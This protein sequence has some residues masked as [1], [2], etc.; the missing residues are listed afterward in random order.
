LS[1]HT[2][3]T[4]QLMSMADG[5][6]IHLN[7]NDPLTLSK[8]LHRAADHANLHGI[9]F[10]ASNGNERFQTYGEMREDARRVT[11]GLARE[12]VRAGDKVILL[13]DDKSEYVP[14]FWGC[15]LGGHVPV[16]LTP[17][18]TAVPSQET[19][20]FTYIYELLEN[21]VII[22]D[23]K[24]RELLV[25][26]R[27]G[28]PVRAFTLEEISADASMA[29][30]HAT[31]PDDPA[32]MM[33]TSGSTGKPKGVQLTHRQV[34][35]RELSSIRHFGFDEKYKSVNWMPLE[36]VGGIIMLHITDV[37]TCSNQ[38]LVNTSYI[39]E[40]PF[41]WLDLLSKH[42]ATTTWAS[43][44]AFNLVNEHLALHPARDWDLSSV[45]FMFNGGEAVSADISVQFSNKLAPYGLSSNA[46][47]PAWGMSETCSGVIFS[48]RFDAATLNGI[49]RWTLYPSYG[50]TVEQNPEGRSALV[51]V[52][53]PLPGIRIKI[54]DD[55][56][57]LMPQGS[58][59]NLM[60]S[61]PMV[62]EQYYGQPAKSA[63]D[64][65]GWFD[66]GDLG[67]LVDGHLILTGR[68]K[69]LI[70]INGRNLSSQ[71][72]EQVVE[73][74]DQVKPA[75]TS[76]C[77]SRNPVSQEE[78]MVVF[79]SSAHTEP[80]AISAQILAI[81][82][83]VV[84]A[85]GASPAAII[86]LEEHEIPR[87]SI[88]KINKSELSKR[89]ANGVYADYLEELQTRNAS[90]ASDL[91]ESEN[92]IWLARV[93]AELTGYPN[94]RASDDFFE[95]GGDSIKAIKLVFQIRTAFSV[96]ISL[97]NVFAHPSVRALAAYIS[98][99]KRKIEEPIAQA[100]KRAS[101][102]QSSSQKRLFVLHQWDEVGVSY[103]LP[104]IFRLEGSLDIA[105]LEQAFR[106]MIGRH[107]ALRT[108]F[109][110]ENGEPVQQV[111]ESVAFTLESV[112]CAEGADETE[113]LGRTMAEFVRPFDLNKAPLMRAGVVQLA[114]N[115]HALLLDM[116]HIISDGMSMDIFTSELSR[117]YNG[118]TLQPLH[119]QYKDYSEWMR[120][121][122]LSEQKNYWLD[123]F[124]EPAPLLDLQTDFARSQTKSFRGH[125]INGL[126]TA[127]QKKAINELC[128]KTGAT[129]YMVLLSALMV[130]L[131]RYS[132]QDDI[133]IGSPFSGR[134]HQDTEQMM[135]MFVNTL[136][137]RGYPANDKTYLDFLTEV[138]ETVLKAIENQEYPFEELV[139]SV[140]AHRDPSRNP[141]FD[142]MFD[143][144]NKLGLNLEGL[145]VT[146]VP[147]E[148]KGAKFDLTLTI[149]DTDDGY[150]M[151]WEYCT[152]LFK[153][154]SVKRM[155]KHFSHL[156]DELTASPGKK[157]GELELA[158]E[159]D[160]RL[161]IDTFNATKAAYPREK[162][163]ISQFEAQ[164]ERTPDH[165]AIVSGD[166][167]MTYRQLN[168]KANQLAHQLRKLGVGP[169][170]RVAIVAHAS[171]ETIIGIYG[172]LKAGGAYVPVDPGYPET[173]IRYMLEDSK[174]KAILLAGAELQGKGDVPVIDLLDQEIYTGETS[175]PAPVHTPDD[176]M[177]IIYT[178]GTTGTPKGVMV[179]HQN[180]WSYVHNFV[181]TFRIGANDRILQQA[182]I[183]FDTS[184]EELYPALI[185]GASIVIV[186]RDDVLDVRKLA[187]IIM[188][189]QVTVVSCS[190]LLLNELN[191]VLSH[192]H[193]VRLFISG[194]DV[195]HKA[196]YANLQCAEVYNTYGPTE[197]TVC[198]TYYRCTHE[199]GSVVPIGKP[200][201][202][203]QV[204]IVS[205]DLRLL[206]VGVP[207]ELCIAG[208]GVARGYWNRPELTA[209]KFV[210]NPFG[211]GR[212]YRSGDLAR[213]LPDGNIEYLGRID[214]QV[215]IRGF[216]VE[217]GEIENALRKLHQVKDVAVAAKEKNG[218]K[219]ICAY[220]V[221][222][223]EFQA[224]DI[225]DDLRKELPDYMVPAFI[226][227]IDRIPVTRNGKLDKRALPEPEA[228]T[229]QTYVAPRNQIE[230]TIASVFEEVLGVRPVGREDNFFEMGGDSIKAIRIVSKIR[231]AGYEVAVKDLMQQRI[232]KRIA[233]KAVAAN[234]AS[235]YQGEISGKAPLTP[236]QIS[237]FDCHYAKPHHYNQALMLY[238]K[239][240][241]RLD[242]LKQSLRSLVV[243]HDMLRGV[244]SGKLQKI[245]PVEQSKLFELH[246]F[247][248]KQAENVPQ[249]VAQE[250]TRLQ[251]SIDLENGP[252]MKA[253][254]FHTADGDH[255]LLC[256][257]HLVVDGVSWRILLE[258]LKSGYEQA[259]Q[260]VEIVL[261]AKTASY[262]EWAEALAEYARS[263]ELKQ[264]IAYWKSVCEQVNRGQ[265]KGDLEGQQVAFTNT[266]LEVDAEN[267]RQLLYKAGKA[268][269]TGINDLLLSALGLAVKRWKGQNCVA[270]ELEGHGREEIH[271]PV[272]IDRTV[273]WFTSVYPVVLNVSEDIGDTIIDTKE[274]LRNIPNHGI[275]YGV[276][277]YLGTQELP[278]AAANLCFNYLGHMDREFGA[279]GRI[280]TSDL[281]YGSIIAEENAPNHDITMN[282]SVFG[283]KLRFDVT[284]N[285][286]KFSTRDI[287]L[288]CQNFVQ[289]IQRI[290]QHCVHQKKVTKTAS[291][292][293][294]PQMS[295]QDF[296]RLAQI[297]P[298][299]EIASIYGLTPMQEGMLYHKLADEHST[300]YVVQIRLG[301]KGQLQMEKV[302]DSLNLLAMK[303]DVLRTAFIYNKVSKPWQIVFREREIECQV[304]DLSG[305]P[306]PDNE[307]LKI[308]RADVRRGFHLE[309][310]GL[311][312]TT[313]MKKSENEHILLWSSHHIITDGWS[314]P[315]LFRDFL[316][317]YQ[318]LAAGTSLSALQE[319]VRKEKRDLAPYSE[320]IRW[321]EKQDKEA[322]LAY[323]ENFLADYTE[324]A[325]IMPLGLGENTDEQVKE[326]VCPL[327]KSLTGQLQRLAG[328]LH[329]TMNTIVET[330]WGI[331]LQKYNRNRDVVFGK[332]VS[333]RNAGI[334]GMEQSVG[335][336]INTIPVRVKCE[337]DTTVEDLLGQM[338][339][340]AVASM[341]YDYCSLAEVQSRSI[342]GGN[343]IRTLFAF[344]N[345]DTEKSLQPEHTGLAIEIESA[346]EQ[347]NY[348][349]SLSASLKDTLTLKLMYDPGIYGKAEIRTL[350][351]R[352]AHLLQQM[353]TNP[354]RKISELTV[355]DE[356]EWRLVTEIFND[357][358]A[359]YPKGK[360][361]VTLFEDQV[362][363]FPDHTALIWEDSKLTYAQLNEK[364]NQL[365]HKLRDLGVGPDDRVA[366]VAQR[367]M[368]M[369][370]GLLG[371]IKAGGAYVPIDPG[372]PENRIRYMLED[373]RPKAILLAGVR[374]PVRQ[375][376]PVI[377]LSDPA[378]YTGDTANPVHV[379]TPNDLMYIIY[380]SGTT[381]QPKGVMIEHEGVVNLREYFIRNHAISPSDV[382]LQFASVSFDATVSEISMS[383]LAGAQLC[384]CPEDVQK[385]VRLFE[386]YVEKHHVTLAIL[387]PQYLAQVESRTFRAV[388]TAGSETNREL[389]YANHKHL[390]YSNDYGPTEVTVCATH[391]AS[392][393]ALPV[394][395]RVPI[396][397]PIENKQIYILNGN[398]L[399]GVGMPG[400]LCIAGVG[401]ARGY[402]NRPELTTEKFVRNPFGEGRLYRSGDLAR[403]LPDGNIE[404]LG[405]IDEQVKI[406]GFRV[407]LGEIESV[408]RKLPQVK[409][410]AVAV[411]EQNG[412]KCICAY[413]VSDQTLQTGDIK[414]SLRKELPEFMVPA[415]IMQIERIPVT[416]NGK[417]DK[418]ALPEPEATSG[419]TYVAPRNKL[420]E[421]IA[422]VFADIL[423]VARV[424]IEDNFFE[425]GGHSLR[426]TR[427]INQIEVK[428]GVRLPL[429]TIFAAPTVR[430]LAK[431]V[432]Q[433]Y[434]NEYLPIPKAEAK[435]VYPMSSAQ[436]RLYV[437]DQME[438]VGIAYNMSSAFE[439]R[440]PLDPDRL[441]NALV[442]MTNRHE[443]LRTSFHMRDGEPVQMIAQ[444]VVIDF[445]YEERLAS[446]NDNLLMDFVRPFDLSRAPLM[447]VK[448]VK[449]GADQTILLVD[450]H[451]IIS[452][453]MSMDLFISEWSSLYNGEQLPPLTVQYKDY[454]EWMRT[455][456]LSEQK[457]YWLNV[458]SEP[459]PVLDLQLD[460][461][462]PLTQ[463]F[464]GH[465]ISGKLTAKQKKAVE[466]LCRQTGTT[467]YMVLLSAMMVL[468][469]KY[470][471]QEDIVIG[472]PVSGRTHKDTEQ[473][474]GMFV[475]T[476]AM[477]GYPAKDKTYLDFLKEV[478]DHALKAYEN[479][480][481]PFEELVETVEVHRDMSRN[482]LFDVMFVLQNNEQR[483]PDFHGLTVTAKD[484]EH[485][486]AKFDLTLTVT[487][488]DDGYAMNWEY[489]AD[490]FKPDSI[491]RMMKHFSHLLDELTTN[492][493]KPIG[494]LGVVDEAEKRL[495]TETFNDSQTDYQKGK[496]VVEVFEAL[497]RQSPDHTAVILED[498][499]MTYAALNA[500]ANQLAYK[501][502]ALGVKPDDFVAIM[503]ERSME[504]VIGIWGIIKAGGAYVPI[505]PGY[506]ESRIRYMLDD[507]RP[508][509]ILLAGA[510]LP[511]KVDIPVIDLLDGEVFTGE[512]ANPPHVNKPGDL[513]YVIYTSGTTGQPKGV[514]IEHEGVVN[515]REY[516]IKD[517]GL[518]AS[519]VVLQFASISFDASV[520]EMTMSLLVGAQLCLCP[521]DVIKD[522]NLFEQYIE[523]HG[524]TIAIL[525]PQYLAQVKIRNFRTIITGG[526]ETSR[527]LVHANRHMKYSNDYGPTEITVAAT[528][529]A[530]APGEP[531]P[532]RIPI[533]KPIANKQ[534]YILN[535]NQLCGIG[536]PG[537]LCVAGV[538][539]ARGYLNRPELTAEK[540]VQNP[541]GEGRMYRSGDLARWLPDGNI[542]YLGRIDEQVKIRG[543]RIEI[544]E[545]ENAIRGLE[546]V[547]EAAVIAKADSRGDK[548]LYAYVTSDRQLD[549]N[550][551][552]SQLLKQLPQYMVPA[553]VGQIDAIPLTTSGKVDKRSLSMM[554]IAMLPDT[555]THVA[556]KNEKEAV[557]C[558]AYKEVLDL[559]QVSTTD[560]FFELGGDSIEAIR[561]VSK[562]RE[563]G[564]HAR[565]RE[566]LNNIS[567]IELAE[568]IEKIDES[569]RGQ[570]EQGS[571]AKRPAPATADHAVD[572][573]PDVADSG[574]ETEPV[575]DTKVLPVVLQD[576]VKVYLHRSLPLCIILA[577]ENYKGWYYSNYIQIFSQEDETGH[578][579]LN[580][581]EPRDSYADV[582]EVI[583]LGYHMFK[584]NDDFVAFAKDKLRLGYYL[585]ANVDEKELK[586]KHAYQQD[587][588]IHSSII[589]GYDDHKQTLLGIGFDESRI[590]TYL[591]F[592][593]EE[594]QRA[595]VSG[596]KHYKKTAPWCEWS[597]IQLVKP[598]TPDKPFAW[599]GRKFLM[600]LHDYVH[601]IADPYRRYTFAYSKDQNEFGLRTYDV[602]IKKLQE[603]LETG[604]V[605]IDYRAI[606]L[607]HEHKQGLYQRI[608]YLD[609]MFGLGEEIKRELQK[610]HAFIEEINN[611]R[612]KWL[613]I[614]YNLGSS[615]I[616]KANKVI[617]ELIVDITHLKNQEVP[618]ITNVYE[619]LIRQ[620]DL[621]NAYPQVALQTTR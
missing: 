228:A 245:L 534:I 599:N 493:G 100:D 438:G 147:N 221:S 341:E 29:I 250:S 298:L 496:T 85:V 475:N 428:T 172:T 610:W 559:D 388:I 466:D 443:A 575:E 381:G 6:H 612:K 394:P 399:C 620:L 126:L 454:S 66:T 444:D 125:S 254:L 549:A 124:G 400:E 215:K 211:E 365:A 130:L 60:I 11:A 234:I 436:K 289:A 243:H 134:T 31:H 600:D 469:S 591:S 142:V 377:D 448:A 551:V 427:V 433:A 515:F 325:E 376:L 604:N 340:Q 169:E 414:D 51:E 158:D 299:Q 532:D 537:E 594:M 358:A 131:G 241:F 542:E 457:K 227:Q 585:I 149:T 514:M 488:T 477:R 313:L 283:G 140:T 269:G 431:E 285:Q 216:R 368:E 39:L 489:C 47:I 576:E 617:K 418:R 104:V 413:I 330:A 2:Y 247:D 398:E 159:S 343:L 590:F 408:L 238:C 417:L 297:H 229:G 252:L 106:K 26:V 494:E 310:G 196:Y 259:L 550:H 314:L 168:E 483:H 43:N 218:D 9:T 451:H 90:D 350:L 249:I 327:D 102:P 439:I 420:E 595:F 48:E 91:P 351:G 602:V 474:M 23:A 566:I 581:L 378:V 445:E 482:P 217:L 257:H 59:G 42:R 374:L 38:V 490:L 347:T 214:E 574:F 503:A 354:Q 601:S 69:D 510:K 570:P 564:Y 244:Y 306:D 17:I 198:A 207:G 519:D 8:A 148:H 520:Y 248:L 525:P 484:Y 459:A 58:V 468:L 68:K 450:M 379:N 88:G 507:C 304:I 553:W 32:L 342:L 45:K 255:L 615:D 533:G 114:A 111:H 392:D 18:K 79:Y 584:D 3:S 458:F 115:R 296:K 205:H 175:N 70:I 563:Y 98:S 538:G 113:S 375:D 160:K 476:L 242:A 326:E 92:E 465:T 471:R 192:N 83:A 346:R 157:I 387:P 132:R 401:L 319:T 103:N 143:L 61:G 277:K 393:P 499:K 592:D 509:A 495:I 171:I 312:R 36:H 276:V 96:E 154:D 463:S 478:R 529:W 21:P 173:R 501:L 136:A 112:T 212:L 316:R 609:D 331:L 621:K 333:G 345:Y 577:Y 16:P 578:V 67:V 138:K 260:G 366:I 63:V 462:R 262:K 204:Y 263:K 20:H 73:S 272:N 557:I 614:E 442:Q 220:I 190:P 274:T 72:I 481:Y 303:Y 278:D 186:S 139:E 76:A 596:K 492:P 146:T 500:K 305:N 133:V 523:K 287:E 44:F 239:E 80:Q 82:R 185:A 425:M 50:E 166:E 467:A 364:A 548:S 35:L 280:T 461:A 288:F 362:E 71:R 40:D 197:G 472:S 275:G 429:K 359:D 396:G 293:G 237:F 329:V 181:H 302:R 121:R 426:A 208:E 295:H 150:A 281:S 397:K 223:R 382:V 240:G 355:V 607:I 15:V 199:E 10:V 423:G 180:A 7:P 411:K 231:E 407:E 219:Y 593:Y 153:P 437:I 487:E 25:K 356:E 561:V 282:G 271:K 322:G 294:A 460:H 137:L 421:T 105:R 273:G 86:P 424:G 164:V 349:L 339:Q 206:P 184:V 94:V 558:R 603:R 268:Y 62:I 191:G 543:F 54:V 556:P 455:R 369:M 256:A 179:T 95:L 33:F 473:M 440:G 174:P 156:V 189:Q 528:H 357:S 544:G 521:D 541:F 253:G 560:T 415:F 200:I 391:W 12:G 434:A 74:V 77:A 513:M 213:W 363:R 526:S 128:R 498:E 470:S 267:T 201:T 580:Y 224:A 183:S 336:F 236:I 522:A 309:K 511:L 517:H 386:Q 502:R 441:K 419:Q 506:P 135:G 178:S 155:M 518:T 14:A 547:K 202:N 432:G 55:A 226:M 587:H 110:F 30:E 117:L 324:A 151:N 251:G 554:E 261:P 334:P 344:T 338:Q 568:Y 373:C 108:S 53:R 89:Y 286:G 395:E 193:P 447:R 118:E 162:T 403:W 317:Y 4:H 565:A 430:L 144:E 188:K 370:I 195:L 291:D 167:K 235:E 163:I 404:Y 361:V 531:I 307:V 586:N 123:V 608:R 24:C 120:S 323:W 279:E 605:T 516:F 416:R 1:N 383:L 613:S 232:V 97:D 371:I 210:Q 619:Q 194:G 352:I 524:V 265:I 57:Q 107:E 308:Q 292:F 569:E 165:I 41:R 497:V 588:Y 27:D 34:M 290:V 300:G 491:K 573:E 99:A 122:D 5:G 13:L 402:L 512:T 597:A 535:G 28:K 87:T 508:K 348:A 410:A 284:Y 409:D 176:L 527:E 311:L 384:L 246:T 101:Y 456:D 405:R 589:Y 453:G 315:L 222:D 93:Y 129:T 536:M 545:I 530:W 335:L 412:D 504:M 230:E 328:M 145:N 380:T 52:G 567:I 435:D 321:L 539:L 301:I 119:V 266:Q 177:Y 170:D 320:F 562:L 616:A 572:A 598:K 116:H 258:D 65:D 233:E 385:D 127:K 270:V 337:A 452:D 56:G 203:K 611:V 485:A 81:R 582:A 464:K 318:T 552:R 49:Q 486:I 480:E 141:L 367:S 618:I 75:L 406:R 606:H 579:E 332:V 571:M 19:E 161:I 446:A 389:V 225:K 187:G 78:E 209:E 555:A 422:S 64:N 360:T 390:K 505:D 372:Y 583:C 479:Q 37:V 109:Y 264:E 46:M 182:S 449:T 353:A 540:F 152:D 84:Q 546:G 22:T